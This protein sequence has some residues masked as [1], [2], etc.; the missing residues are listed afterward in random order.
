MR[1][2]RSSGEESSDILIELTC[3]ERSSDIVTSDTS[4]ICRCD[5]SDKGRETKLVVDTSDRQVKEGVTYC[6]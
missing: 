6:T 3:D 5:N 2:T 1:L 4:D